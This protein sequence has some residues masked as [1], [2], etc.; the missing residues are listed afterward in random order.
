MAE[1]NNMSM[2]RNRHMG[3]DIGEG[4]GMVNSKMAATSIFGE[5]IT[6]SSPSIVGQP[7][8]WRDLF[9]ARSR[10]EGPHGRPCPGIPDIPLDHPPPKQIC[11]EKSMC[12]R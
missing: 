8:P 7:Q 3:R 5:A 11:L 2:D 6:A 9:P 4:M 1:G 10:V 12:Q